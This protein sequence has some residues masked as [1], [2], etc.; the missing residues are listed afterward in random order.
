MLLT[1]SARFWGLAISECKSMH[2]YDAIIDLSDRD[3]MKQDK[4]RAG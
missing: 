1:Q 3:T 2:S 4:P